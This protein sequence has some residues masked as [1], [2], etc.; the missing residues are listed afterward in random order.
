MSGDFI[1]SV[2][3]YW[4]V[5]ERLSCGLQT[6]ADHTTLKKASLQTSS[7]HVW[8]AGRH[9]LINRVVKSEGLILQYLPGSGME[10]HSL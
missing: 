6:P 4:C 5:L 3:Q 10:S 7:E 2:S 1:I 8:T 9:T